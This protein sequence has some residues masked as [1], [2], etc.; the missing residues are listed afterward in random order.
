MT[1]IP[2]I[3]SAQGSR[4]R[5]VDAPNYL[6]ENNRC[7]WICGEITDELAQHV[8]SAIM[9]LDQISSED[10]TLLINSPG[11]SVSAGVCI[12]DTMRL[13]RSRVATVVCGMAASMAALIL[14]AGERG[15][16]SAMPN[17]EVMIHQP[18]TGVQGAASDIDIAARRILG[19]KQKIA[20]FLAGATGQTPKL[21]LKYMDRDSWFTASE[22]AEFG[23]C[24]N[25]CTALPPQ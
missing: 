22:A 18:L 13:A 17:S 21:I 4:E 5:A 20:E 11:G 16:R 25:I 6:F 9:V 10:I 8:A 14:A 12:V 24:D 1:S 19:T 23:L 2:T 15:L 7:I 3:I